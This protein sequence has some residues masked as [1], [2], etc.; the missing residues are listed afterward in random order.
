MVTVVVTLAMVVV[1]V[2]SVV[3]TVDSMVVTVDSIEVTVDSVVKQELAAVSTAVMA[4]DLVVRIQIPTPMP[5]L[6]RHP[7][8]KVRFILFVIRMHFN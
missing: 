5:M 8:T 1:T 6:N 4:A 7:Q 3:V 2:D